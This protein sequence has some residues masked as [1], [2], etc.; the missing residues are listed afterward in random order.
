[1]SLEKA[2]ETLRRGGVALLP[3]DT[4]YGLVASPQSPAALARIF[5]L[6]ARPAEKNLPILVADQAQFGQ[7]GVIMDARITSLVQSPYLPGALTLVLALDPAKAPPW[8]AG[9]TEVAVRMPDDT[10]LQALLQKTGPLLATS[11]NTSGETPPPTIAEILPQ[12]AGA[13]DYVLDDGPRAGTASTLINCQTTPFT[14]L[15]H[16]A[17][18]AKALAELGAI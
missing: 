3:T 10:F 7:L 16:G 17:L 15:R 2:A 11:A 1:M 5:A 14:V 4:V 6:K 9:R 8:L 13:P 12:L 18:P